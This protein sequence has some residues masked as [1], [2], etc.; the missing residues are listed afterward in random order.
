M[1]LNGRVERLERTVAPTRVVDRCPSCGL[2]RKREWRIAEVR[3]IIGVVGGTGRLDGAW[4]HVPPQCLCD[5]GCTDDHSCLLALT[6]R[7]G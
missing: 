7:S 2:E 4:V 5:C 1:R 6:H 3:S